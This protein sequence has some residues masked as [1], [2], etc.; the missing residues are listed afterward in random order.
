MALTDTFKPI[1]L[2]EGSKPKDDSNCHGITNEAYRF[3]AKQQ[4][5]TTYILGAIDIAVMIAFALWQRNTSK[6]I[7]NMQEEVADEQMRLAEK[8]HAHAA[9]FWGAEK[10]LV[11]EAFGEHRA[12]TDYA[13][14][15]SGWQG[16]VTGAFNIGRK[17]WITELGRCC[18]EADHCEDARWKRMSTLMQADMLAFGARQSEAR[19]QTLRDRR[20]ER[21]Y[22]ALK[23]GHNILHYSM[24]FQS[25]ALAIGTQAHNVLFGSIN[26]LLHE[27]GYW[28]QYK[29][30]TMWSQ[31]SAGGQ[32]GMWS[33]YQASARTNALGGMDTNPVTQTALPPPNVQVNVQTPSG[34][35]AGMN[36][37]VEGGGSVDTSLFRDY[38]KSTPGLWADFNRG[39]E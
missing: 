8:L 18:I 30:P 12:T 4:A 6:N 1:C 10:A 16:C 7:A 32:G 19:A 14:L 39:K 2:S 38:P 27:T 31:M 20:Y 15:P 37:G 25:A 22:N 36:G 34:K 5:K 26:S 24:Q 13:G 11:D 33:G 17:E 21:Q 29:Q 3:S 35:A 9:Q 28:A 23:L